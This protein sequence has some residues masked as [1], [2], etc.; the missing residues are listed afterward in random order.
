[1]LVGS[2]NLILQWRHRLRVSF[3]Q[4]TIGKILHK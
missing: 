4:S 2:G 1:L 3:L